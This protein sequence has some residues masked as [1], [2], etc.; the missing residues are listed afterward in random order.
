MAFLLVVGLLGAGKSWWFIISLSP[1]SILI[2]FLLISLYLFAFFRGV[3]RSQKTEAEHPLTTSACYLFFY[4]VS[5]FLGILAGWFCVTGTCRG[6]QYFP[7]VTAGS[8]WIT[9][10][11]WIVVDPVIGF[12]EML[13]P[14][15]RKHRR[16]RLVDVKAFR[17]EQCLVRQRFLAEVEAE[18]DRQQNRWN[19][20]LEPYADRLAELLSDRGAT[21]S[22]AE[23]S[24]VD[25]GVKAWRMGGIDCMRQLYSM[26]KETCGQKFRDMKAADFLSI[27]WDG[28][29]SWRS[30]PLK[31]NK[32]PRVNA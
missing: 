14:L 16:Q 27:W 28:I 18:R 19:R 3:A 17:Q 11:V 9:F 7:L 22:D 4:D 2:A 8:F 26:T 10:L 12:L 6:P 1:F 31:G 25:I 20:K 15:S 21:D 29:G 24:S 32:F 13:L 30:I 5:P 23:R